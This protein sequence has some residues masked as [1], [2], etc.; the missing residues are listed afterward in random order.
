MGIKVVGSFTTPEGFAYTDIYLRLSELAV[1]ANKPTTNVRLGFT[2]YLS[3]DAYDSGK[4]SLVHP[5]V[6]TTISITVPFVEIGTLAWVPFAY[7]QFS[8]WLKWKGV[9]V[10]SVLEDG[11][12]EY[13]PSE[14]LVFVP[15]PTPTLIQYP[16]FGASQQSSEPT[17]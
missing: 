3:K 1:S 8:E 9:S 5:P 13:T 7:Y 16:I 14:G 17:Q 12:S 2:T 15:P 6:S 11:Q 10:E 4:S